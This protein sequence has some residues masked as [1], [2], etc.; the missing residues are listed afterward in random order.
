M[1]SYQEMHL[2]PAFPA[3][4]QGGGGG[5]GESEQGVIGDGG[6]RERKD[7]GMGGER[8]DVVEGGGGGDGGVGGGEVEVW[9]LW[10]MLPGSCGRPTF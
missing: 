7:V 9:G 1:A 6:R 8:K 5:V 2:F 10:W 4:V 3:P